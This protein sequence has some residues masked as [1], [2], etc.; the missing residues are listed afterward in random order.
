MYRV[1]FIKRDHNTER[2]L[3][4]SYQLA[5]LVKESFLTKYL[6][7][8]YEKVKKGENPLK[9]RGHEAPILR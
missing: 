8:A 5:K 7:V 2:C 6:E 4:L 3:T 9:R 1:S